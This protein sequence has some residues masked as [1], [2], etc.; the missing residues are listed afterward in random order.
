LKKFP[1]NSLQRV[2]KEAE[3]L[4]RFKKCAEVLSLAVLGEKNLLEN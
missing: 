3:F 1:Q 4:R 2:S